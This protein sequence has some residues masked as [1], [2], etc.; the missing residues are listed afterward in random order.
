MAGVKKPQD[1]D[2]PVLIYGVHPIR[3]ILEARPGDVERV[4]AIQQKSR[5]LGSMLGT[6]RKAGIPVTYLPREQFA[7]KLGARTVHQGIAAQVALRPY[8]VVDDVCDAA[9]ANPA[10]QLVLLDGVV[11]PRNLGAAIRTAAGAGVDGIILGSEK[12]AGLTPAAAK[13]SA[14]A[15]ERIPVAR[16]E[17]LSGRIEKLK[18]N[19]F[20]CVG[21]DLK[22][23]EA[24]TDVDLTG[25]IIYVAGG[26]ERGLRP[27]ISAACDRLLRIPLNRGI[28]SLNVAVA[29]GVLLFEAARQRRQ[30]G[31]DS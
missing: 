1:N 5:S 6:A 28:E 15:I 22:G 19:G 16:C 31:V 4:F 21:L 29:L 17:R 7:R 11:D 2:E 26:E 24:W 14:G 27:G 20:F 9:C 12:T 3:E 25:R 18:K 30:A 23:S 8:A 10:G 13:T